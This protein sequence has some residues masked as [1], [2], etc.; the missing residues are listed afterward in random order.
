MTLGKVHEFG[1]ALCST[2]ALSLVLLGGEFPVPVWLTVAAP[3]VSMGLRLRGRAAPAGSGTLLG[4]ASLLLGVTQIVVGGVPAAVLGGGT[5]LIG[6]LVARVLTRTTRAHDLQTLV[7]ALLLVLT[8]AVLNV[9]IS[10]AVMF[11]LFAVLAVWSL[12]TRQLLEGAQETLGRSADGARDVVEWRFFAGTGALSVVV[13]TVTSLTFFLFPR[14]GFLDL[15]LSP[16]S[17]GRFPGEVSLSQSPLAL[18]GDDSVVAVLSG[19]PRDA[20]ID[21]L[22]LRGGVYEVIGPRGFS[23]APEP[24]VMDSRSLRL[25]DGPS[26]ARYT[27]TLQPFAGPLLFT[28]GPVRNAI[29]TKGGGGNPN[30]KTPISGI[31]PRDELVATRPLASVF[32]YEVAGAI[33]RPGYVPPRDRKVDFAEQPDASLFLAWPADVD[34]RVEALAARYA[35]GARTAGDKARR[36][37]DG[38]LNDYAYTLDFVP[39]VLSDP[40]AEFLFERRTGHCELFATAYALM[41]R[42]Q[43]VPTRIVGG[44]QG[45]SYDPDTGDVIFTGQNAHA[46]VEWLHEDRGWI[47]DDPTPTPDAPRATLSAWARMKRRA[48]KFWEDQVVDYTFA[49]QVTALRSI[50]DLLK[51]VPPRLL[52][53]GVGAAVVVVAAVV[54]WRRRRRR[55]KGSRL[56]ALVAALFSL[57]AE[58]RPGLDLLTKTAREAVALCA[59][60][61]SEEERRL[62]QRAVAAYEDGRFAHRPW[63]EPEREALRAQ[64]LSA[65]R[66]A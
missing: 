34:P 28:L 9:N 49:D 41:L 25:A 47:V 4:L 17:K 55:Q 26:E 24:P 33:S 45:G 10:Y 11:V 56:D 5:A 6:L 22:Y 66:R 63:P 62:C 42:S 48:L 40:L 57:L 39:S 18:L 54:L 52:G 1:L 3:W 35:A 20:F 7:L 23:R 50:K 60:A 65:R 19:V 43:G 15:H 27:V 64:L 29:G 13:L 51:Q 46:W 21:G 14:I 30:F 59:G 38:L 12:M 31:N 32:R 37:R 8:G 44:Y 61:L 16:K 36:I 2:C 58:R 53:G